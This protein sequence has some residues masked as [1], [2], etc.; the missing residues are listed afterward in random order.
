MQTAEIGFTLGRFANARM[1]IMTLLPI[2][3]A[4]LFGGV[5]G[6]AQTTAQLTGSVQDATGAIIPGAKVTLTDEN[7]QVKQEIQS[8]A[9]GLYTFPSL[10]PSTY[11]IQVSQQGFAPKELTGV[12]LH[13]G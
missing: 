2:F 8:N 6:H 1:R 10:P 11:T 13:A 12:A 7:S 5:A 9:K 3:L 4:L